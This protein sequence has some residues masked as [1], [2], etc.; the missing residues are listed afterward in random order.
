MGT[1]MSRV[2]DVRALRF[3]PSKV[4][5]SAAFASSP[6]SQRSSPLLPLL[7]A[8]PVESPVRLHST[9]AQQRRL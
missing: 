3:Q 7:P 1:Q 9:A 8:R 2:S 4:P 5:P 6:A